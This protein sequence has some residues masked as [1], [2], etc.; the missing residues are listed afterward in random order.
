MQN[1]DELMREIGLANVTKQVFTAPIGSWGGKTGELF[2]E[3]YRLGSSSLQPLF[4]SVFNVPKEEVER[5]SALMVK[6]FKSY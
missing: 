3:D 1:L 5:K 6:G 4:T 2:A